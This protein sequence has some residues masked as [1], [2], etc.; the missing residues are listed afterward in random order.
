[1]LESLIKNF[2]YENVKQKTKLNDEILRSYNFSKENYGM[3]IEAYRV[4]KVNQNNNVKGSENRKEESSIE[5]ITS[6]HSK[7]FKIRNKRK[8]ENP[9]SI[10]KATQSNKTVASSPKVT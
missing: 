9:K 10:G 2:K 4:D 3:F 7:T 5:R 1:M 8:F 6:M